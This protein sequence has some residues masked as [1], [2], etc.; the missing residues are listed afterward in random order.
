MANRQSERRPADGHMR[1]EDNREQVA[2]SEVSES[3]ASHRQR[4]RCSH[5]VDTGKISETDVHP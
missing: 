5:D 3:L 2:E 1:A 4:L